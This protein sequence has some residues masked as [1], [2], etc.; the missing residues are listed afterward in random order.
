M[1][2]ETQIETN[3]IMLQLIDELFNHFEKQGINIE[4]HPVGAIR[5]KLAQDTMELEMKSAPIKDEKYSMSEVDII[6]KLKRNPQLLEIVQ[7]FM[8]E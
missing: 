3:Q 1:S 4:A 6:E 5:E 8:E 7:G 2:I